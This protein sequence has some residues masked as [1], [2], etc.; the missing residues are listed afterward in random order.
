MQGKP[1]TTPDSLARI[2]PFST[3]GIYSVGTDPPRIEFTN[4]YYY[5]GHFSK[6]IRPGAKRVSVGTTSNQLTSTAFVYYDGSLV[7]V[8]LNENNHD[9]DYVLT[10]SSKSSKSIAVFFPLPID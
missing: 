1:A 4:S 9:L 2:K 3:P 10:F 6:F 5:R 8:I 7:A